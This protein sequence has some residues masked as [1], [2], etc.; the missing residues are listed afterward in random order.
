M[1]RVQETAARRRGGKLVAGLCAVVIAVLVGVGG[2]ARSPHHRPRIP[3]RAIKLGMKRVRVHHVYPFKHSTRYHPK[4]ET[5]VEK[6]HR[7]HLTVVYC[8]GKKHRH[9]FSVATTSAQW[10]TEKGIGVGD[11]LENLQGNYPVDCSA[12]DS[13]CVLR[14]TDQHITSFHMSD[15]FK[16]IEGIQV[17]GTAGIR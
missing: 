9:V 7:G 1:E 4:A 15:D 2:R 11:S 13:V 12:D 8:C 16:F 3:N 5:T 6:Y 14:D 10:V 17:Y